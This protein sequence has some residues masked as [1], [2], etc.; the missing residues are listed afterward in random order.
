MEIE[1]SL[2]LLLL[3]YFFAK[4]IYRKNLH[5]IFFFHNK[6]VEDLL[7]GARLNMI[8]WSKILLYIYM[9]INYC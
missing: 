5:V 6:F 8:A 7:N 4:Q 3:Q 9:I 2:I 1:A